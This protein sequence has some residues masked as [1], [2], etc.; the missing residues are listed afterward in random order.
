MEELLKQYAE[1]LSA[2]TPSETEPVYAIVP[3][4]EHGF[5]NQKLGHPYVH[6]RKKLK[7]NRWIIN[8]RERERTRALNEGYERLRELVPSLPT[9][10]KLSKVGTLKL[11][12]GYIQYLHQLLDCGEVKQHAVNAND[13]CY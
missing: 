11:A 10:G 7:E 3:T 12:S 5:A 9:N 4:A 8:S 6:R 2:S 13:S 1:A